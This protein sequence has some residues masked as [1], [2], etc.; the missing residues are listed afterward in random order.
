MTNSVYQTMLALK[1]ALETEI[2]QLEEK[3]KQYPRGE[4]FVFKNKDGYK[5]RIRTETKTIYLPQDQIE[6]AC[7]YA[8]KKRDAA[9]LQN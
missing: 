9:R 6:Q 8:Q 3:I 5:W 1:V 4:L 2:A 7:I